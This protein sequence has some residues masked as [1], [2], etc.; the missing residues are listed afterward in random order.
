MAAVALPVLAAK[1]LGTTV[2]AATG[3]SA[4]AVLAASVL[5]SYVDS[6]VLL[7][8]LLKD[9]ESDEAKNIQISGLDEGDPHSYAIGPRTR[10]P[11]FLYWTPET[12]RFT[13]AD[14]GGKGGGSSKSG[15]SERYNS[16]GVYVVSRTGIDDNNGDAYPSTTSLRRV[17]LDGKLRYLNSSASRSSSDNWEVY[18]SVEN[19]GG[20]VSLVYTIQ[21]KSV[22]PPPGSNPEQYTFEDRFIP[23]ERI[24]GANSIGAPGLGPLFGDY[25]E[26]DDN[27]TTARPFKLLGSGFLFDGRPFLQLEWQYYDDRSLWR[28]LTVPFGETGPRYSLNPAFYGEG[29]STNTASGVVAGNRVRFSA[30]TSQAWTGPLGTT[31]ASTPGGIQNRGYSQYAGFGGNAL[32]LFQ[33]YRSFDQ[34]LATSFSARNGTETTAPAVI[35]REEVASPALTSFASLV[36]D[37]LLLRD[38]G[39]RM[40][41]V[42]VELPQDSAD[43]PIADAIY[44]ILCVH[45]DLPANKIDLS[46]LEDSGIEVS[47]YWWSA[48]FGPEVL[49]PLVIA[50]DLTMIELEGKLVF[51]RR[52]DNP[53]YLIPDED[54]GVEFYKDGKYFSVSEKGRVEHVIETTVTYTDRD[55]GMSKGSQVFR[56]PDLFEGNTQTIDL[57]RLTLSSS[58]ARNIAQRATW[59]ASMFKQELTISLGPKWGMLAAGDILNFTVYGKSWRMVVTEVTRGVDGRVECEG[60]ADDGV[61]EDMPLLATDLGGAPSG[62]GS[63]YVPPDTKAVAMDIGPLTLQDALT[64]GLYLAGCAKLFGADW[65]GGTWAQSQGTPIETT[66]LPPYNTIDNTFSESVVGTL[67]SDLPSG[68]PDLVNTLEG[69]V[70]IRIMNGE[71]ESAPDIENVYDREYLMYI[72]GEVIGYEKVELVPDPEYGGPLYQLTGQVLRGLYNTEHLIGVH[73]A[74]S[75]VA[76]LVLSQI[77]RVEVP[78][79]AIDNTELR[80][81]LHPASTDTPVYDSEEYGFDVI[82][83]RGIEEGSFGEGLNAGANG[84][85]YPPSHLRSSSELTVSN[86]DFWRFASISYEVGDRVRTADSS[87][88]QYAWECTVAHSP[89][90]TENSFGDDHYPPNEAGSGTPYWVLID[91]SPRDI[92]VKWN[93]RTPVPIAGLPATS[94]D[95]LRGVTTFTVRVYNTEGNPPGESEDPVREV[96]DIFATNYLYTDAQQE[97]DGVTSGRFWLEVRADTDYMTSEWTAGAIPN[98][99]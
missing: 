34:G 82:H 62:K 55:A 64:P 95:T 47:G 61:V 32:T 24:R 41:N 73:P 60:Y 10:M 20:F 68:V 99:V 33:T 45:H 13:P 39:N 42:E 16:D 77:K 90:E 88:E 2:G 66:N 6:T 91:P 27:N 31:P 76:L 50:Y 85:P 48:P 36:I 63:T 9:K 8:R 40:P 28:R 11:G 22:D 97:E 43:V 7:P 72:D 81:A 14:E 98:D 1:A 69:P 58:E 56:R 75:P 70:F 30:F 89:V 4:F 37:N 38:F 53:E 59:Q 93:F 3:A 65:R 54:L 79:D 71:L 17:W 23:G 96:R 49:Q 86:I 21:G 87:G 44:R 52:V 80:Y 67:V 94:A 83:P 57:S 46:E 5:G 19:D 51:R 92:R 12:P 74:G 26:F 35:V 25:I 15:S 78:A 18:E 84:R 29:V